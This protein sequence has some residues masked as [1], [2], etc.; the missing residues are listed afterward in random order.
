MILTTKLQLINFFGYILEAL[1]NRPPLFDNI[2]IESCSMCTGNVS[3]IN[4]K[5]DQSL[6]P[7]HRWL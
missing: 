6:W 2:E 1:V 3:G 4:R 5:R 7:L